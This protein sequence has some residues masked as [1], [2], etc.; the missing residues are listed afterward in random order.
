M[1]RWM[2][3]G[4]NLYGDEGGS[5]R[6]DQGW[7]PCGVHRSVSEQRLCETESGLL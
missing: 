3:R 7:M 4:G 2:N 1:D 5:V 6:R